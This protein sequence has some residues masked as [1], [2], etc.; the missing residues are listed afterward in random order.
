MT[1]TVL[2]LDHRADGV[3]VLTLARPEKRNALSAELRQAIVDTLDALAID[4]EV[5]AVVITGAGSTFCAGFDLDEVMA[6]A[7][8]L[9]VFTHAT[10]YHHAVHT[11]PKP[12]I[13][14]VEGAAVAGGMD[15]ALL[16]DLRVCAA[17]ARFGQPQVK[18][19]VPAAYDLL[20]T[21]M[22][23]PAARRLCLTGRVIDA[24][25]AADLGVVHQVVEPGTALTEALA[26]AGEIS[27]VAGAGA[28]KQ[29]IV[30]SQPRL[31]FPGDSGI[32]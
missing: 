17:D 24:A 22:A 14:A 18:M 31:F 30:A 5:N 15:L 7:N 20:A 2:T 28:M 16:C 32:T 13:A 10:T 3:A 12:L 4:G 29:A 6:A 23:P 8:P 25:E 27:G 26:L 9:E 19:G 11:F 1:A 21:V